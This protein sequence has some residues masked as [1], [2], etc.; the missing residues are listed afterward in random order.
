MLVIEDL[1]R[2]DRTSR[3]P[4]VL[5]DSTSV[6][7]Y[8]GV[9]HESCKNQR[10]TKGQQLKGK[11]VSALFHTFWHFLALFPSF[12]LFSSEFFRIFPPGLSLRNK[13]FYYCFSSKRRK[14]FLEENK[15]KKTKPFCTLVVARLASA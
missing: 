11:I 5:S 12:L 2:D 13:G 9:A 7:S 15:K 8:A 1:W 14:V 6:R 3:N 4:L 10:K